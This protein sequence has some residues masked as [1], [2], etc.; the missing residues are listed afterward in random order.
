MPEENANQQKLLERQERILRAMRG[1][2]NDRTP[3][4]FAGPYALIRYLDPKT[5]FKYIV[6][7]YDEMIDRLIDDFLP[8]FPNIDTLAAF[9]KTP[10]NH[11]SGF[12][13]KTQIPGRELE[14]NQMWQLEF[15]HPITEDDYDFIIDNGWE[16]FRQICVYDRLGYDRDELAGEGK[17]RKMNCQKLHDAGYPFVLGGMLPSPYDLLAFGRG[18]DF[19]MDLYDFP[20]KVLEVM[21]II[22]EEYEANGAKAIQEDVKRSAERGEIA[23]YTVA[24]CVQANC[25]LISRDMFD[26]F[27]WPLIE[28]EANLVLDNGAYVFFHMDANWTDVVDYFKCFPKGRCLYDTDGFTDRQ[29]L[30]DAVGS[31]MA[32]TASI[33]PALMAFGTPEEVYNACIEEKEALG[34]ACVMAASCTIPAN[35]PPENIDALYASV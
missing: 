14:D 11:G 33:A 3:L 18:Q 7:D 2:E 22:L 30:I 29:K 16:A 5:N 34:N 26:I 21:N 4:M 1:E 32:I 6:N 28:R 25:D 35:T 19:F 9:G 31:T 17:S 27:G 15:T 13:A 8:K 20:E 10:R 24:P 23:V 12:M